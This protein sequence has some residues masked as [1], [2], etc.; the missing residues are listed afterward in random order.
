[1]RSVE[2]HRTPHSER[3]SQTR[4]RVVR[5]ELVHV[6]KQNPNKS[7]MLWKIT[8]GNDL[9][10][11]C[12]QTTKNDTEAIKSNYG[13]RTNC[14]TRFKKKSRKL[15]KKIENDSKN[16]KIDKTP[17]KTPKILKCLFETETHF[18]DN[19]WQNTT[20]SIILA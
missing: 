8:V 4:L 17:K 12:K 5:A 15:Q 14:N 13:L 3:L 1:M 10:V 2:W 16:D 9:F 7:N 18:D 11:K 20:A 19:L 6:S